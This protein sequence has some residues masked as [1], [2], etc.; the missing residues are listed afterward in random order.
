M[1]TNSTSEICQTKHLCGSESF[2]RPEACSAWS[3]KLSPHA[4]AW[5]QDLA[6]S[7]PRLLCSS[8]PSSL[9]S[10]LSAFLVALR[11]REVLPPPSPLSVL[12]APALTHLF[13]ASRCTA[14]VWRVGSCGGSFPVVRFPKLRLKSCCCLFFPTAG[15]Q[16]RAP[17]PSCSSAGCGHH[18]PHLGHCGIPLTATLCVP[19]PYRLSTLAARG[20]GENKTTNCVTPCL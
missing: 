10:V 14:Y 11:L 13:P 3:I 5:H 17:F 15:S 18:W 4:C 8:V 2:F 12:P 9:C 19:C 1:A 20:L 6:C 7:G 16:P